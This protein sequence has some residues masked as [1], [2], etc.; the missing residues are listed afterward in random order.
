[1]QESLDL[2]SNKDNDRCVFALTGLQ[3]GDLQ[4]YLSHL[5]VFL[6]PESKKLYILVDNQPWLSEL[7]SRPTLLWQLMITKSRLSP[8]ANTRRRKDSDISEELEMTT[9]L[10]TGESEEMK[11]W[12]SLI[13]AATLS[14]SRALLPVKK[15]TKNLISNSK[16]HKTLYGFIVFEILWS[17]V[18]G[19]N[20]LN[21]LQTDT[22]LA[23]EAKVMNRWEFDSIRQA[24]KCL[25][26]WFQGTFNE[27]I[28]LK[29]YLDST[30][31]SVF[32]EAQEKFPKTIATEDDGD[33]SSNICSEDGSPSYL[34]QRSKLYPSSEES[35]SNLLETPSPPVGPYK[36]R[37][38]TSTETETDMFFGEGLSDSTGS[39]AHSIK[40]Y[41]NE[42]EDIVS[43]QYKDVLILFRFEDRD[44]PFKLKDIIMSNLRL[45]TLLEAG[46]PS[47]VI[48]LQSYPGFCHI[49][50]PW[51]CP[52]AR[53]LYVLISIVTVLIGFYDLYKNVPLLKATAS[54]L[55]GPL[56]DW[57]EKWEMITRIRYLGTMLFLHNFQKEFQWFL[58]TTRTVRSFLKII[59][60]PMLGPLMEFLDVIYPL[61]SA[62]MELAESSI[63]AIWT[64]IEFSCSLIGDL[65]ETILLPI[66]SLLTFMW[67]T[68]I[69]ILYPIFW[70]LYAPIRLAFGTSSIATYIFTS[71][72]D[73]VE[74]TRK[75]LSGLFRLSSQVSQVG[76]TVN[77]YEVSMWRSL[78]ND[79]F[80]QVFKALRAILN[81]FVA[82]FA[83]CNR[84]RLSI[85]NH[86]LEFVRRLSIYRKRSR[87][88]DSTPGGHTPEAIPKFASP[89]S[90][91]LKV[92]NQEDESPAMMFKK[93]R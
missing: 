1:M 58:V 72:W 30:T 57:V 89:C 86:V 10:K 5:S 87:P 63:S 40:S 64:V 50:R 35:T 78:W 6:A 54:R 31:G 3:I 92:E 69:S 60:Q 25:T 13:D 43:R 37:K 33:S 45:L 15:L 53:A 44:L 91:H 59:I 81:G 52:L 9:N 77:S 8:F 51:M 82:F 84:H 12:F 4:S 29:E 34:N 56:F 85:Y 32:S 23:I 17:D 2:M 62:F 11:K 42:W 14:R 26:S 80:S 88:P 47:W 38:F 18:R 79:L 27:Q 55:F 70:V 46:L 22:S 71:L 49:Y 41:D 21:E 83:A 20:Y 65:L 75:C 67:N 68:V 61:K 48:F 36:R 90:S 16:L 73:S 28:L 7:A 93:I 24:I 76:S 66:W 39:P 74:Y 19:L